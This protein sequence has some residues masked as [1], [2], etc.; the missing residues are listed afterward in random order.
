MPI[1]YVPTYTR[2]EE[3]KDDLS[4]GEKAGAAARG[5]MPGVIRFGSGWLGATPVTGALSGGIGELLAEM[6]EKKTY[7]P[8]NADWRRVGTEALIGAAMGKFAKNLVTLAKQ[9]KRWASAAQGAIFAGSAPIIRHGIEEGNFNPADYPGEITSSAMLGAGGGAIASHLMNKFTGKVPP[10]TAGN[11]A[12]ATSGPVF[13]GREGLEKA[14]EVLRGLPVHYTG[15]VTPEI[16]AAHA[17]LAREQALN[18]T[19]PIASRLGEPLEKLGETAAGEPRWKEPSLSAFEQMLDDSNKMRLK[20]R[21]DADKAHDLW[22]R[23]E[24]IAKEKAHTEAQKLLGKEA[25]DTEKAHGRFIDDANKQEARNLNAREKFQRGV[26]KAR[27]QAD[28]DDVKRADKLLSQ[29]DAERQATEIERLRGKLTEPVEPNSISETVT[30]VGEHGGKA[31]ATFRRTRPEPPKDADGSDLLD[32]MQPQA[33]GL[34]PASPKALDPKLVF[35][36]TFKTRKEALEGIALSGQRGTAVRISKGKWRAK[37][38]DSELQSTEIP[39]PE[40]DV[41]FDAPALPKADTGPYATWAKAQGEAKSV[42]G[43]ARQAKD[44]KWYVEGGPEEPPPAPPAAPVKPKKGGPKGGGGQGGSGVIPAAEAPKYTAKDLQET[45]GKFTEPELRAALA[46]EKNPEVQRLLTDLI[47]RKGLSSDTQ[48]FNSVV[49]ADTANTA[50]ADLVRLNLTSAK[51]APEVYLKV[52]GELETYAGRVAKAEA[53]SGINEKG[54]KVIEQIKPLVI[55]VPNGPILTVKPDQ[56][57]NVIERL[58]KGLKADVK[59]GFPPMKGGADVWSG[60]VDDSAK[61]KPRSVRIKPGYGSNFSTEGTA[62]TI[63]IPIAPIRSEARPALAL[64]ELAKEEKAAWDNYFQLKESGAPAEQLREAGKAA[65]Q[66]RNRVV[67]AAKAAREAGEEL[68]VEIKATAF[69]EELDSDEIQKLPEEVRRAILN[70]LTKKYGRKGKGT[71]LGAGLG[72]GQDVAEIIGANPEYAAKLIGTLGGAGLGA[73]VDD[74]DPLEGAIIGGGL[75][76]GGGAYVG[77][78]LPKMLAEGG[79]LQSLLKPITDRVPDVVRSSLLSHPVGLVHNSVGGP[80]GSLITGGIEEFLKGK[81]MGDTARA[82]TGK[83]ILKEGGNLVKWIQH[84]IDKYPEAVERIR[85]AE[86]L[87]RAGRYMDPDN[88]LKIDKVIKAPAILMLTGDLTTQAFLESAGVPKELAKRITLMS[89][90]LRSLTKKLADF[91]RG[92]AGVVVK[93]MLPFART[94]ANI[95]ERGVER[96]PVLGSLLNYGGKKELRIPWQEQAIQQGMGAIAWGLGFAIGA[97]TPDPK[98]NAAVRLLRLRNLVA[99]L[100]GQYSLLTSTGFTAGQMYRNGKTAPEAAWATFGKALSA[101]AGELPLPTTQPAVDIKASYDK[102]R[103]GK[104]KHWKE[105]IPSFT[106]PKVLDFAIDAGDW[107]DRKHGKRKARR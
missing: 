11:V 12:E 89:E 50:G 34:V 53:E 35:T 51:S 39:H 46:M 68:P 41:Q 55:E 25:L 90:P 24:R 101:D 18:P 8:L 91:P 44:G 86:E 74:K 1:K 60:I 103:S 54:E 4:I 14:V 83:N 94:A 69:P 76:F 15:P 95:I 104:Y 73:A 20:E 7:N 92:D 40:I 37:A 27:E 36:S 84:A 105:L 32:P 66:V 38:L 65:Q 31:K 57:N 81:A 79:D 6:V 42:G 17:A 100:G 13:K 30:G 77:K 10:S 49:A 9:G 98:D 61:G 19:G 93:T 80:Y 97:A 2:E 102:A 63:E 21:Q 71:T 107:Y 78:Q 33:G 28:V 62:P 22:L 67:E 87:G 88:P 82:E 70:K 23:T 3:P 43:I 106:R 58:R 75:G 72:G 56:V 47:R 59:E 64:S 48:T 85:S 45:Y 96:T 29:A 99:N 26:V 16:R 52:L 5:A